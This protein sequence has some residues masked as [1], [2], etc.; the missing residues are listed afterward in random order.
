MVAPSR[1]LA[2]RLER[3]YLGVRP[4]L[5]LVPPFADDLAV[6]HDDR[7]DHRVRMRRAAPALGELERPLQHQEIAW[8]RPR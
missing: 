5:P 6:A 7:A 1:R 8:T 2:C 3:D 4:A